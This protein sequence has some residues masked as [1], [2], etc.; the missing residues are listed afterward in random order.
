MAVAAQSF[1]GF[2]PDAI[3]FLADLAQNNDRAWFQPRKARLRA[4]AEGADGGRSASPLGE[5]FAARGHPAPGRPEALAVPDLPRHPVQQ[6]QVAVQD[7]LRGDSFPWVEAAA[8]Q[9]RRPTTAPTA[10]AATSTSSRARCTPAAACGC[11]RSRASTPSAG[12]SS[13]TRIACARRSRSPAF[14]AWFGDVRTHES[15]KRDP[16]RAIR[17]TT[18]WRT[19]SAGRTSSSGAVCP[20]PRSAR[21]SLPDLPRRRL[22][23]GA[24]GLPLPRD[25]PIADE[26]GGR[27]DG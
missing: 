27:T 13:T 6:G 3:Q 18:R 23:R 19:C 26:A 11:P 16:A 2:T 17:R 15:L 10:T 9:G 4:P 1:A 12:R 24:A 25:A 14:V 21:P 22:R 7:A 5:R 20:T 8:G